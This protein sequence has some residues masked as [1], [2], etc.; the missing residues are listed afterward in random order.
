[1]SELIA[2]A[3][4]AIARADALLVTAGA[5]MGVDSGLPDFRGDEGFWRAY[6]PFRS[7]GLSFVDLANPEWFERDPELAWGFYGHRLNLYRATV[8]HAGFEVLRR[9]G[10]ARR[11]GAFVFTSNVDGAFQ[12][13][14]FDLLRVVECHGAID[15]VQCFR[16]CGLGVASADEV[17]VAV[18]EVTFR[19]APPLPACRRCGGLLRPNVLMFG[20][21]EWVAE[22]TE[23][24]HRR[25]AAW[26]RGL[27]DGRLCVVECGAGTAIPTVRRLGDGLL[28]QGHAL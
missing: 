5:G 19:A 20:D 23:A 4:D 27:G 2:R 16:G 28:G 12:R 25:F 10:E 13:A 22:R 1:M 9:W 8:P 21:V 15:F 11:G 7:L 17:T 24:Q 14:G 3:A 6:P 26:L 18:D